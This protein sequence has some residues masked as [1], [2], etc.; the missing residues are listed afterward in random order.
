M[1]FTVGLSGKSC[2]WVFGRPQSLGRINACNASFFDKSCTIPALFVRE[3]T[4]L[5]VLEVLCVVSIL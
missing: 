2:L 5:S 1:Q 3:A 4:Y